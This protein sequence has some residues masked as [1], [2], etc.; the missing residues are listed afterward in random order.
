MKKNFIFAIFGISL[1][2]MACQEDSYYNDYDMG[3]EN[4]SILT[5]AMKLI[6]DNHDF[7]SLP[8]LDKTLKGGSATR[9][10]GSNQSLR[11]EEEDF[12]FD[13]GGADVMKSKLA[14]VVVAP[15]KYN[16]EVALRTI[17]LEGNSRKRETTPLHSMLYMRKMLETGQTHAYIL[18][19]A[20]DRDYI[21]AC[22][23]NGE[24]LQLYPNPQG[25]DFSGILFFSTIYGEI[26]HGIRYE[27]GRKCYYI[28]PRSERNLDFIEQYRSEHCSS[29][30]CDSVHTHIKMSL[31]FITFISATRSTYSN[32]SEDYDNLTCSFCGKN[33]N[34]CTC[35]EIIE[36]GVC[37]KQPCICDEYEEE[38][39]ERKCDYCGFPILYCACNNS[40]GD[41]GGNSGPNPGGYPST[42]NYPPGYDS[43]GS[44]GNGGNTNN[45]TIISD[46]L[47]MITTKELVKLDDKDISTLNDIIDKLV[48][49]GSN[50]QKL[51]DKLV[52]SKVQITFQLGDTKDG[53]A[54]F[55]RNVISFRD[56]ES[57]TYSSFIEEFIHAVQ[58]NCFYNYNM[59]P[60]YG[61]FEL[62]AKMIIDILCAE[63]GGLCMNKVSQH[64]LSSGQTYA[65]IYNKWLFL[66]NHSNYLVH[67]NNLKAHF[68]YNADGQPDLFM[69]R[70]PNVL[71]YL[72]GGE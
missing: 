35:V 28:M 64:I 14:E 36:C 67:Y 44:S 61:N 45:S 16:K 69:D 7:V 50:H 5:E 34:D 27:N 57:I 52:D 62:E 46:N 48:K 37:K 13:W 2:F 26:T 71:K 10:S 21:N 15:V 6:E 9:S 23:E 18:S 33:V 63:T 72:Y 60:Q 19:F 65:A 1:L 49:N 41:Q 66:E 40:W 43:G 42:P 32:N 8:D 58:Y 55:S 30:Q 3:D 56:S 59:N 29:H 38:E 70:H 51:F 47:L 31:E 24:E 17:T 12:I 53:P 39:Q 22:E 4:S 11:Y 20:P 68:D 54:T 25:S